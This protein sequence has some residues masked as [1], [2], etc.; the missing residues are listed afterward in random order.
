MSIMQIAN[1]LIIL[2]VLAWLP[3][4][5][6]LA[7]GAHPN[8]LPYLAFHLTGV[9]SGAWLR[10]RRSV[11]ADAQAIGRSRVLVSK[12]MIYLGVLAWGPYFYLTRVAATDVEMT[13]FLVAHLTG[14]LGGAALRGSVEI[15]RLAQRRRGGGQ[16]DN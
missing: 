15:Q 9:L 1:T 11:G 2:G 12:I 14:V 6:Q 13:G 16:A 10:S 5:W 8:L 4:F 3:F 7:Q